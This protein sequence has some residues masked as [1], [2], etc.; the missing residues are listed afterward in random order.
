M[1][2]GRYVP[3][4]RASRGAWL[5]GSLALGLNASALGAQEAHGAEAGGSPRG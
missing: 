1:T 4:T 3:R 2:T 5:L